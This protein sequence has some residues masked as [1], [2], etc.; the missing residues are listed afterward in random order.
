[1]DNGARKTIESGNSWDVE[2]EVKRKAKDGYGTIRNSVLRMFRK[3][4]QFWAKI[5]SQ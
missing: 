5:L 3:V 4:S 2:G 1:M